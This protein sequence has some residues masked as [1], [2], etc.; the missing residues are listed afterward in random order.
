MIDLSLKAQ[1]AQWS[2]HVTHLMEID[3]LMDATFKH[4]QKNLCM[5]R[6]SANTT[7]TVE[8]GSFHSCHI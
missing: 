4:V 5:Y 8:R 2:L 6:P 3:I 1:T 7:G